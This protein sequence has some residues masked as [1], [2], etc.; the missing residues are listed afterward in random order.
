MILK[1]NPVFSHLRIPGIII[2]ETFRGNQW[3]ILFSGR[4]YGEA[5]ECVLTSPVVTGDVTKGRSTPT[6]AYSIMYKIQDKELTGQGYVSHVDY[7]MPFDS[8]VGFHDADW[9]HGEFGGEIYQGN[10]SHGCVNM[11]VSQA[12]S[13]YSMIETGCPVF[14]Y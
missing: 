1:R 8:N 7:W 2:E 5:C 13:F 14:V 10:G 4:E 9:R 6:G 12:K 11:P 3:A